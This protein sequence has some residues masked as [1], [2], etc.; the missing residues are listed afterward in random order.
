MQLNG[1]TEDDDKLWYLNGGLDPSLAENWVEGQSA[2]MVGV[3]SIFG[4]AGMVEAEDGDYNADQI[5]ETPDRIFV[6]PEEKAAFAAKQEKLQSGTNI[7][8]INDKPLLGQGNLDLT[9]SDVDAEKAGNAE[10][11]VT[12]HEA[13]VNPHTQYAVLEGANLPGGIVTVKPNGKIDTALIEVFKSSVVVVS[14][15]DARLAL[16]M[17]LDLRIAK[18]GAVPWPTFDNDGNYIELSPADVIEL[19]AAIHRYNRACFSNEHKLLK[20][21]DEGTSPLDVVGTG[22]PD[23]VIV[24]VE[25]TPEET[26]PKP[27][28]PDP[29]T[30]AE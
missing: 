18:E 19:H 29:E 2:T 3:T 9:Y 20:A 1:P 17:I 12:E 6:S 5:T 26:E 28:I 25:E 14:L 11:A 22:W 23:P 21:I 8:T 27:E 10:K 24:P 30:P 15:K 16:P 13:K 7:K 4:R